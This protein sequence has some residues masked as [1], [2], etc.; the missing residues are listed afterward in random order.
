MFYAL[1]RNEYEN[2]S[3]DEV[4]D[5]LIVGLVVVVSLVIRTMV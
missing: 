3:S 2:D 4:D 5:S 1:V